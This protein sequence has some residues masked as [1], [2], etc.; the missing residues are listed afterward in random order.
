MQAIALTFSDQSVAPAGVRCVEPA[1]GFSTVLVLDI[2]NPPVSAA[3]RP[4]AAD[5]GHTVGFLPRPRFDFLRLRQALLVHLPKDQRSSPI[6]RD[7]WQA[8]RL[9]L[10]S[11]L[12]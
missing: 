1:F 2:E 5:D 12:A 11:S 8:E 9:V 4:V 6:G 7:G 10:F 3:W